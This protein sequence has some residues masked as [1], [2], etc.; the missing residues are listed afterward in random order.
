MKYLIKTQKAIVFFSSIIVVLFLCL[1]VFFRYILKV[2]F[3]GIEELI[4]IPVFL[5]Y[6]I[7]ASL[8]SYENSHIGADILETFIKS[9]KVM[10]WIKL[11]TLSITSIVSFMFTLWAW[12]YFLFS[13]NSM[14]KTPGWQI[15]L[16]FPN[17]IVLIGF[18]LMT[19]F[20]LIHTYSQIKKIKEFDS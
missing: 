17:G 8:G 5:L 11:L 6:F 3:F 10:N 4:I 14:E 20:S 1:S 13:V 19:L 9:K 2:D 18:I 15:P 16:L 7:G 12:E